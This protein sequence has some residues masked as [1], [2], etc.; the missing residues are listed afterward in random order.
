MTDAW[1]QA[2]CTGGRIIG[3]GYFNK[4]RIEGT[5]WVCFISQIPDQSVPGHRFQAQRKRISQDQKLSNVNI[6]TEEL[7]EA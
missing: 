4:C 1:H 2:P 5:R 7:I 6:L 3:G